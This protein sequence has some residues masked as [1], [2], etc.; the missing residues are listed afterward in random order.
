MGDKNRRS[1][2]IVFA[3]AANTS[4]SAHPESRVHP[5]VDP[6]RCCDKSGSSR[7]HLFNGKHREAFNFVGNRDHQTD[8]RQPFLGVM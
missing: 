1:Q 8:L 7:G 4:L 5:V 2:G 6:C 3:A